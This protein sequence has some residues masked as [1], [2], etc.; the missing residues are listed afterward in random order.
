MSPFRY[1]F[2]TILK[3][4]TVIAL[5]IILYVIGTM[6][7]YSLIGSGNSKDIFNEGTW[8]H[9]FDFIKK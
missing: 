5:V 9:I 4:L 3:I 6:I 1:I 8:T 7:G 2:I